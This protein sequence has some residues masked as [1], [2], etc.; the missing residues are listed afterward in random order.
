MSRRAGALRVGL[1]CPYDLD[2]PGGVRAQVLGL[3]RGLLAAGHHAEVLAPGRSPASRQRTVEGVRTVST[4]RAE[5]EPRRAAVA[6]VVAGDFD[7][8]HVHEPIPPGIG[9][10]VLDACSRLPE[11]RR[12]AGAGGPG[13]CGS[14]RRGCVAASTWSPCSRR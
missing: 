6:W 9:H 8:L 13:R 5:P 1:V 4:G 3:A 11:A 12:P 2:V 14:C 10:A 7:V